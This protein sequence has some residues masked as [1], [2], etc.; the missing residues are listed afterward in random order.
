M[1]DGMDIT[2]LDHLA[3]RREGLVSLSTK[4]IKEGSL[5]T[6]K[7]WGGLK[8]MKRGKPKMQE[9][10]VIPNRMKFRWNA[11]EAQGHGSKDPLR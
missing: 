9:T 8:S 6:E 11:N 4:W 3:K 7:N 5:Q 2:D 1:G 10:I